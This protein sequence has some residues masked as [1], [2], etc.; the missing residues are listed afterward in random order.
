MKKIISLLIVAIIFVLGCKPKPTQ[1]E[2]VNFKKADMITFMADKII[3]PRYSALLTN[4]GQLQ[5]SFSNFTNQ[6]D[7][8]NLDEMKEAWK[9]S[10]LAFNFVRVFDFGPARDIGLKA[11]LGTFPSDTSKIMSNIDSGNTF[12]STFDQQDAI[13]LS[14]IEFIL[15][16]EN[17]F[18]LLGEQK[19]KD[20]LQ[21]LI[22][23][24]NSELNSVLSTWQASYSSK[25]KL[26]TGTESTSGFSLLIN[27]F[28]KDYELAK[29]AKIGIPI[30]KQS[31]GV[32]QYEYIES[33]YALFSLR[34]LKANIQA[35]DGIFKGQDQF[36]Q[37]AFGFEDYLNA[38]GRSA[39]ADEINA[40]INGILSDISVLDNNLKAEIDTNYASLDELYTKMQ[41]LVVHL[42]T[43]MTSAFGVLI[44]YQDNDGD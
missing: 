35:I 42:K 14:A 1:E 19:T 43:D 28:N 3:V 22:S 25:F 2:S 23:K 39:L 37:S 10:A 29:N 36:G 21:L 6:S 32:A 40:E 26:S 13:G 20:Y 31:L 8:T 11:S 24:A 18:A 33:P 27:E 16:R 4:L 38:L 9:S 30:G 15:F 41:N 12:V 34:I 7:Q 44:T 17:A 5:S